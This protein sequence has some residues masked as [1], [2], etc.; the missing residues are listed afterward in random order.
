MASS[1]IN[2]GDGTGDPSQ[3][4]NDPPGGT[5]RDTQVG[6]TLGPGGKTRRSKAK[7]KTARDEE[8]CEKEEYADDLQRIYRQVEKAFQNQVVRT[9]NQADYWDIYECELNSNQVYNGNSQCYIAL[10]RDALLARK[11]RFV[12]QLFPMNG[13]SVSCVTESGDMPHAE[14]AL[15]QHY[16]RQARLRTEIVPAMS[17]NG[18]VE[19]QYNLYVTWESIPRHV[20]SRETE[21]DPVTG[22][23][24]DTVKEEIIYEEGPDVECL[25]DA[26][27]AIFP[28]TANSVA[29]AIAAGGGVAI[30]RRWTKTKI[31]EMV[32]AGEIV[33]ELAD[34]LT[35]QMKAVED[36]KKH[37]AKEHV[38]A[39]GIKGKGEYFLAREVWHMLEVDGEQRM[40]RSYFGSQDIMFLGTKLNP[41]WNDKC[42]VL[43]VPVNKMSG[44]AKG[45]SLVKP[46][47][48]LQYQANDFLN[49]AADSATFRMM[50]IVAAD[51]EKVPGELILDLAARWDVHPD[52]VKMMEFPPLWQDGFELIAAL[53]GQIQQSL[54][55][56]PSMIPATAGK[57]KRSQ[58]DI[59]NE[60]AVDVLTTADSV[61]IMEEGM[62]TP[63][64]Q[65]F[66]DLDMQ[67]RHDELLI[68]M[69]GIMGK[70][71]KMQRIK[72]LQMNTRYTFEWL[73]VQAARNAAMVQQQMAGLNVAAKVPPN[74]Y[75][76]HRMDFTAALE[77][78]FENLFGPEVAAKT[79]VSL[80]DEL[81][82][83]P[84]EENKILMMGQPV[85]VSVMDDDKK[86]IQ[87]HQP[88]MANDPTGVVR[89]HIQ[90]HMQQMQAK[91]QAAMMQQAQQAAQGNGKNPGP[92][93]GAASTAPRGGQKPA[94]SQHE[95]RM[96]AGGGGV[97][98]SAR[99]M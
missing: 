49:E 21:K 76:N 35:T 36:D 53:K 33:E 15:V 11:T 16:I 5:A 23:E 25:P 91:A 40:C 51:P 28:A 39:S 97:M 9:N 87:A 68:P 4:E 48:T 96:G 32:D 1:Y 71:A 10:T 84:Q 29:K 81:A 63:L 19:G 99:Q 69:Y 66:V 6:S 7:K 2:P 67:F 38:S 18:D 61:T 80:Q 86:H 30:T 50:P 34:L 27:V 73:G 12:N 45:A 3:A 56:N 26:D 22:E 13:R 31:K 82:M 47:S 75:R 58:A 93:G 52:N 74:L 14:M 83:D 46:I 70:N 59:A 42:P 20:V 90:A 17:V 37:I 62:L 92:R 89:V 77:G 78:F 79:F 85:P 65:W 24:I 55:V 41:Y 8:L 60:Q 98:P 54:G 57:A 88:L 43:S 94:G 64:L 72:P 44:A 95:D